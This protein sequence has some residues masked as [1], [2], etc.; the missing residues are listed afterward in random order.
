MKY[1]FDKIVN[2]KGTDSIKW[3]NLKDNYG[4][5]DLLPMWVADMDF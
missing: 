1:N 3:N 2:R 4:S 5:E